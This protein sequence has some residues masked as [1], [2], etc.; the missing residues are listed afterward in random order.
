MHRHLGPSCFVVVGFRCWS[1]PWLAR[2]WHCTT[3]PSTAVSKGEVLGIDRSTKPSSRFFYENAHF[4]ESLLRGR[5]ST[6]G[7][8]TVL[9][10]NQPF[11]ISPHFTTNVLPPKLRNR[12]GVNKVTKR[13]R[14]KATIYTSQTPHDRRIQV[15]RTGSLPIPRGTLLPHTT[16]DGTPV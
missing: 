8:S 16:S 12:L 2:H 9:V 11:L 10:P 4:L 7:R 3:S 15:A 1:E 14:H 6:G 5:K 13:R